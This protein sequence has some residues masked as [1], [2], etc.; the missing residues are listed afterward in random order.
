[1]VRERTVNIGQ[2]LSTG[3]QLGMVF[4]VEFSEVRLPLRP[5]DLAFIELPAAGR[6]VSSDIQVIL[7]Q[8][9]GGRLVSW[10]AELARVEGTVDE[11]SRMH[12]V[13]VRVA[14]PYAL[15]S[16][17]KVS[18]GNKLS[19]QH[20]EPFESR[21]FC[22]RPFAGGEIEGLF[23]IP[24]RAVYADGKILVVDENN[25]LRYRKVQPVYADENTIYVAEGLVEGERLC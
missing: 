3:A 9:L 14:D 4:S 7:S 6:Q 22:Y 5:A 13:V 25:S 10:E 17:V 15:N 2:F 8:S 16:E 11:T 12:Y 21:Q 20:V 23:R 18:S 24:R 1:M 19:S